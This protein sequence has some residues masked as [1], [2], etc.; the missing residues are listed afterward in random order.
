MVLVE[1]ATITALRHGG[2][3]FGQALPLFALL[4]EQVR[5]AAEGLDRDIGHA[6]QAAPP[7]KF[8]PVLVV[9]VRRRLRRWHGHV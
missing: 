4:L 5:D 3:D 6:L 1:R 9:V 7:V 2:G 8:A